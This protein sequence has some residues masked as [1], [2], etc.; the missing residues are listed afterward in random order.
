MAPST[1]IDEMMRGSIILLPNVS[2]QPLVAA[3]RLACIVTAL[4]ARAMR[5]LPQKSGAVTGWLDGMVR[6]V[7]LIFPM[8]DNIQ[9]KSIK[10]SNGGIGKPWDVSIDNSCV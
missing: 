3:G 4:L 5:K 1:D 7:L 6:L 2:R 9:I 10:C 8:M